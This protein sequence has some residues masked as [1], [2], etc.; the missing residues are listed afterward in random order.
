[1]SSNKIIDYNDH[2]LVRYFEDISK[3]ELLN[4]EEELKL[5]DKIKK[6]DKDAMSRLIQGNLKFVVSVAKDYQCQGTTLLDLISD[7]NEGL[8]KA[9][10]RF[11]PK[12]GFRFISYAVWWVR[13]SIIHGLNQNSRLVRLPVN[14]IGDLSDIKKQ[15][16]L[17]ETK[18]LRKPLADE[19]NNVNMSKIVL[20]EKPISINRMVGD[21]DI[22]FHECMSSN[23]FEEPDYQ[24]DSD[25]LITMELSNML[26]NLSDREKDIII[27]YFG[28][29]KS[30]SDPIT[31]EAIGS[32]YNI[33][34]E[35]VRQIK[36][37]AIR[38]L[39]HDT[40][41]LYRLLKETKN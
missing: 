12:R 3:N 32:K 17:F 38:K 21:G 31:L 19:L 23:L 9:A 10:E 30:G 5:S 20:G 26:S 34:K 4:Q 16:D 41:D 15:I 24:D 27:L 29:D 22:E 33:T 39:R 7:G 2:T 6:G 25:E 13:Q 11:D 37:K 35:R 8:I 18:N 14:V 36:E 28:L 40:I 1:M